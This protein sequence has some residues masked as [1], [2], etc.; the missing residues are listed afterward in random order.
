MQAIGIA[1]ALLA[2][3]L[4][5]VG[6]VLQAID[7]RVAPK[8]LGLRV[9]LLTRLLRRPLWVLGLVL[10]LVGVLPQAVAYSKAAFVV[11]QPLLIVGLLLVLA[12]GVHVLHEH[13][14]PHEITG[15]AA[16]IAGVALVAWGAPAHSEVHRGPAA[17]LGVFAGLSILGLLPFPLRGTRFDTGMLATLATGCGLGATNVGTKLLGDNFNEGHYLRAV[18]WACLSLAVGIAATIVNMSA[19]QRRPATMVVPVSTALQTFL[20]IVVEPLFLREDWSSVGNDGIPLLAGLVLALA[21]TW[22]IAASSAVADVVGLPARRT[23]N[24]TS[25]AMAAH[26]VVL[27]PP[28]TTR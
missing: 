14:G 4:F 17:V 16:I 27:D 15:T 19:F 22:L 7:A 28:P 13:V 24:T 6:I 11:V 26:P 10:S 5:N 9:A 23:A 25:R 3:A 1:T 21:G 12:L 20:P 18:C 2:S 8:Q